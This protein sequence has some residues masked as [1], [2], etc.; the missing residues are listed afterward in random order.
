[1]LLNQ[2]F[3]RF[4]NGQRIPRYNYGMQT[5]DNDRLKLLA[6]FPHPDDETLGMGGTI[7]KYSAESI[8]TCLVCATRGQR[9]WPRKD[10]P[11]P[12]FD[13]LG[14]MRENELRC[15]AKCLGIQD[16]T[17][18][19][20]LDGDLDQANP[21]EMIEVL[22][23]HIRRL[24]PQ[25][26]VTFSP[27]GTYGH[28]DHIAMAQFATAAVVCA[29]D[30]AFID[31]D[32]QP[33]HRVAKFY[34]MVDDR[35]TVGMV[36]QFLGGITINVDDVKRSMVAWE[37]W[38]ITTRIDVSEFFDKTWQAILCHQSQLPGLGNLINLPR[39]TVKE[40]WSK[41]SFVRV[42]SL[43]NGGRRTETDLFEGLRS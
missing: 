38:A 41:G 35:K 13:V 28:P 31:P 23:Q 37:D 33:S 32:H 40:I 20:Y 17:I 6:I 42:F 10:A 34:H 24:R 18:L 25:V 22:V 29:S 9:G 15:A 4:L 19:D 16:L 5:P 1:M 8:E 14:N 36:N 27:D 39:E 43:V 30:S 3:G 11:H 26:V 21:D 2:Q 7:A 12:G